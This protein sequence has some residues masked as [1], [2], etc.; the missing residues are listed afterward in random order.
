[1]WQIYDRKKV[2]MEGVEEKKEGWEK[3]VLCEFRV[4]EILDIPTCIRSI[5]LEC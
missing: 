5:M 3:G 1:M 4:N 2:Q